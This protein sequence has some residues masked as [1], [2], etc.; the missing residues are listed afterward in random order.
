MECQKGK[1]S[2]SAPGLALDV[3]VLVTHVPA[4]LSSTPSL[5]STHSFI[6]ACSCPPVREVPAG[7]LG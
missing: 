1:L 4:G 5:S 3:T 7:S 2:L 6:A